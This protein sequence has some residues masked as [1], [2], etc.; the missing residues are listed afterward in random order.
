M[1]PPPSCQ[2]SSSLSSSTWTLLAL[3]MTS[4]AANLLLLSCVAVLSH[5]G[6]LGVIASPTWRPTWLLLASL[7]SWSVLFVMLTMLTGC[8]VVLLPWNNKHLCKSILTSFVLL[9][10]SWA[11]L[12]QMMIQYY[13]NLLMGWNPLYSCKFVWHAHRILY[14]LSRLLS[15]RTVHFTWQPGVATYLTIDHVPSHPTMDQCQWIWAPCSNQ[16]DL[17]PKMSSAIAVASVAIS[18]ATAA[19]SW[20]P[21]V[22]QL[23]HLPIGAPLL[24]KGKRPILLMWHRRCHHLLPPDR[25]QKT[26]EGADTRDTRAGK[27]AD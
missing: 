22:D 25:R 14:R 12:S 15:R 24:A 23:L 5:G 16:P 19:S 4:S 10:L 13:F 17:P 27:R 8:A 7:E 3:L 9:S 6:A 20:A 26:P 1:A 21:T 11:L 2:T 18:D